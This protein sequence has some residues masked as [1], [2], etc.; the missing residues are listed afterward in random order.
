MTES[1]KPKTLKSFQAMGEALGHSSGGDQPKCQR[2]GRP[3]KD[4][5]YKLCW[6]CEQKRRAEQAPPTAGGGQSGAP[7]GAVALPAGYLESG[8]FDAAGNLRDELI[9]IQARELAETFYRIKL[10][11]G[12][13][14]R[15]YTH[16][17]MA[18]RRLAHA[19]FGSI[20]PAIL[21]MKPLVADAVGRARGDGGK[22]YEIFKQFIDANVDRAA[23]TEKD[24]TQ[25]FVPHFQYIIA[26]FKYLEPK[27]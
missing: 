3:V 26:Y 1:E 25:G 12:Q 4:P 11:A 27:G 5:K 20:R 16:V 8:Y 10:T 19:S 15:F 9:T 13:L 2:C 6:D 18:E 22:N 7:Q 24:L 14:R 17:R 23:T 21:E